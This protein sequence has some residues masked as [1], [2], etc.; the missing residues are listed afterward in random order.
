MIQLGVRPNLDGSISVDDFQNYYWLKEELT[1][2]CRE[3]GIST[4]GGK[5]T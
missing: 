1:E 4:Q 5:S 3:K 2:F